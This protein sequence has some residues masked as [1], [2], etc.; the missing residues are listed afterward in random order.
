MLRCLPESNTHPHLGNA[1]YS[2]QDLILEIDSV[3]ICL[4]KG[5]N[6]KETINI[7][8]IPIIQTGFQSQ[9]NYFQ[10]QESE[11]T[12]DSSVGAKVTNAFLTAFL[13][14]NPLSGYTV[15]SSCGG[16]YTIDSYYAGHQFKK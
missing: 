13:H 5:C 2:R 10:F 3:L 1:T 11:S 12:V 6:R 7:T 14:L 9:L 8:N 15:Q 16:H 4:Y